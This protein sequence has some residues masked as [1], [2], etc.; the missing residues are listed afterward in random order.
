MP[1][2]GTVLEYLFS[3]PNGQCILTLSFC[4]IK[5]KDIIVRVET[6]TPQMVNFHYELKINTTLPNVQQPMIVHIRILEK[7]EREYDVSE[8]KLIKFFLPT[9]NFK[10]SS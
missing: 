1:K 6:F 9:N 5:D 4:M 2:V 3:I 7:R 8:I 10:I